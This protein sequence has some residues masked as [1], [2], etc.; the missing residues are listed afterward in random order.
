MVTIRIRNNQWAPVHCSVPC[1]VHN[2]T[3]NRDSEP[4]EFSQWVTWGLRNRSPMR[5]KSTLV[6]M[7]TRT[8]TRLCVIMS[9]NAKNGQN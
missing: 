5:C 4:M 2:S 9:H 7:K 8:C 1:I 3:Q 6:S